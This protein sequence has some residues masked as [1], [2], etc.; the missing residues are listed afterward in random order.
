VRP[1]RVGGASSQP[2]SNTHAVDSGGAARTPDC[3]SPIRDWQLDEPSTKALG[4]R[5]TTTVCSGA[6][7]DADRGVE[8]VVAAPTSICV[9][10]FTQEAAL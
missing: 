7:V 10:R 8:V 5:A 2:T 9:Y 1:K 4:R 3:A 6:G